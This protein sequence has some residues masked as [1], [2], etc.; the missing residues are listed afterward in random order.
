LVLA[1]EHAQRKPV[2]VCPLRRERGGI[3]QAPFGIGKGALGLRP[4]QLNYFPARRRSEAERERPIDPA[5]IW[6][7]ACTRTASAALADDSFHS[8]GPLRVGR[9]S[10]IPETA[11]S[12]FGRVFGDR[13]F[14]LSRT[15]DGAGGV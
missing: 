13:R 2:I 14:F 1:E 12:V 7:Q 9:I 11:P 6:T 5:K 15:T 10:L 3:I 8:L 4:K